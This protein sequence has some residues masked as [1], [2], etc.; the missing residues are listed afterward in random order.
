MIAIGSHPLWHPFFETLA[1]VAGY[2]VFRRARASGDI[3]TEPQRWTVIAA[4][5][6][7]AVLGSRVL[8]L[9]E[10]WPTLLAARRSGHLLLLAFEPGGKTIVGGLLGGWLAVEIAKRVR[11]IRT[12]TGD[13]FAVPLCAG[14]AIGRLGCF[15]AGLADDTYGRPTHLPWAIDFGDCIGRH[16]VQAYEIVFLAGLGWVLSR[17]YRLAEGARFRIFMAAYLAWR[18]FID[19]LKPQPLIGGMNVIQWSCLFGLAVLGGIALRD[20]QV[21]G[22]R[23]Y[24]QTAA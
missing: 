8:G 15:L 7:G 23:D 5:A 10:Q 13:L 3:L 24:D 14:I 20:I 6:I 21:R 18:L 9:A 12:R 2:A 16:P 17:K 19:F 22:V 11:G 1:Y 4:A